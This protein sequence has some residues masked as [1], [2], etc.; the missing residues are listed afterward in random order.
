MIDLKSFLKQSSI[1]TLSTFLSRAITLL[2]VPFYV[3]VLSPKD[4]GIVDILTV[5]VTLINLTIAFE[6]HQSVARFYNDWNDDQ[7]PIYVSTAFWFTVFIYTFFITSLFPFRSQLASFF[8][9]DNTRV[10]EV[11]ATFFMAWTSGL[12]YFTQSQLRWQLK[13]SKHA[14]TSIAFTLITSLFTIL[15]V[16]FLKWTVFGVIMGLAMGNLFATILAICF[17]TKTYIFKFHLDKALEML[18]FSMPLVLS[19]VSIFFSLF[20]DRLLIKQLLDLTQLGLFSI[21]LKFASVVGLFLAGINNALTPLIYSHH[22]DEGTPKQIEKIFRLFILFSSVSFLAI[23]LSRHEILVLFTTKAYYNAASVIPIL[24]L[25]TLMSSI[26]NFTPGL[27]IANKTYIVSYINL[28]IAAVN[29]ILNIL[30]I[31][32]W[33]IVGASL[34]TLMGYCISFIIYVYFNQKYYPI[35]FFWLKYCGALILV[36]IGVALT[37]MISFPSIKINVGY[38]IC[39]WVVSSYAISN[40]LYGANEVKIILYRIIR[41]FKTQ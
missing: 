3:R 40:I 29:V 12:Y 6:I 4:Y 10:K 26:Y 9:E 23:T 25:T 38:K 13:A 36:L 7:K 32:V 15:F 41:Y 1:Y 21:G 5:S 22:K 17:T 20:I 28:F 24:V 35:N 34:G 18:R 37:E 30:L 19:S 33:G 16:L 2:L 8:I 14:M 11:Y 39:V 27:F 31:P